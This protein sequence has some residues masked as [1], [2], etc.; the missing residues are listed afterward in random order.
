MIRLKVISNV[1]LNVTIMISAKTSQSPR[2]K[3]NHA[4]SLMFSFFEPR[5]K[6]DVPARKRNTGAQ[7]CVIQ[8]VKNSSGVV[9]A[10]SVGEA[11]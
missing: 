10:R 9:E 11:Y 2:V 5:R 3:R 4:V 6:A 1:H 8:R 7:K